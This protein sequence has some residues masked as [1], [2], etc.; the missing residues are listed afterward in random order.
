VK[1]IE[2]SLNK[3]LREN[4]NKIDVIDIKWKFFIYH[5]AMVIYK[6]KFYRIRRKISTLNEEFLRRFK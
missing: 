4:K 2:D 1:K 6:N 3:F 5:Y